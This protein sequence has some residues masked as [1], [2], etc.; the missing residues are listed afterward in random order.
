MPEL[1]Y[2]YGLTPGEVWDMPMRQFQAYVRHHKM[3]QKE[4]RRGA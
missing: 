4:A 1:S 2:S 3:L